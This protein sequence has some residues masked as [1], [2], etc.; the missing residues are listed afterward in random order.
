M[1]FLAGTPPLSQFDPAFPGSQLPLRVDGLFSWPFPRGI[2]IFV[3]G[4]LGL[5]RSDGFEHID[6]TVMGMSTPTSQGSLVQPEKGRQPTKGSIIEKGVPCSY[7]SPRGV[8]GRKRRMGKR[9][10]PDGPAF[11]RRTTGPGA[12]GKVSHAP[13]G[14]CEGGFYRRMRSARPAQ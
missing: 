5:S 10:R 13:R 12:K 11:E 9:E 7:L 3:S 6:H 1:S 14:T 4:A 2:Y 8:S